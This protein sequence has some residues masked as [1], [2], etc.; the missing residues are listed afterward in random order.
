M[1]TLGD[2]KPFV[3]SALIVQNSAKLCGYLAHLVV[4]IALKCSALTIRVTLFWGL[5]CSGLCRIVAQV[6]ARLQF[7]FFHADLP[8]G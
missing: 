4:M 3:F 1:S 6:R 7:E 5:Y 8:I 2:S